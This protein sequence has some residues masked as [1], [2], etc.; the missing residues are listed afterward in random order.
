[1]TSP[2]ILACEWFEEQLCALQALGWC[3]CHHAAAGS[4]RVPGSGGESRALKPPPQLH[5]NPLSA[6]T[7][8]K[9][10]WKQS[11]IW[12]ELSCLKQPNAVQTFCFNRQSARSS[13]RPSPD[14]VCVSYR[15]SE[16]GLNALSGAQTLK[17]GGRRQALPV[18]SSGALWAGRALPIVL[19]AGRR[20]LLRCREPSAAI[21]AI[22]L[23]D[24]GL[25]EEKPLEIFR[26]SGAAL[27]PFPGTERGG[28]A[29]TGPGRKR[30]TSAAVEMRT[31]QAPLSM[32]HEA[33]HE[34]LQ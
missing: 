19:C 4:A 1:M 24:K 29:Q 7:S 2:V 34:G 26:S 12:A 10:D 17:D 28:T 21:P 18:S 27:S 3:R 31:R 33:L 5:P 11:R 20:T 23:R 8:T 15:L 16:L 30:T 22:L 13:V 6:Y 14:A 25:A 9:A 32:L